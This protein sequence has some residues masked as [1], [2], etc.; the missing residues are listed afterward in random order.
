[1]S[2]ATPAYQTLPKNLIAGDLNGLEQSR[3]VYPAVGGWE[4]VE[5]LQIPGTVLF[6][7]GSWQQAYSAGFDRKP[8]IET[9]FRALVEEWRRETMVHSSLAALVTHPAYQR[10]MAMGTDALPLILRELREDPDH[11]FYALRFIAGRD[12][13]AGA[14]NFDEAAV[15][16]LEW[17]YRN[18]YL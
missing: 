6:F 7:S 12:V 11:W 14:A 2:E 13:A 8:A 15:A 18:N 10:I 3:L 1:M 17:G 5:N 4:G 9:E 16:W